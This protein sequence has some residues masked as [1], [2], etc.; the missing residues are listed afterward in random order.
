[1]PHRPPP[2]LLPWRGH[3]GRSEA[4]GENFE[5][6]VLLSPIS[7]LSVAKGCAAEGGSGYWVLRREV[8]GHRLVYGIN[9]CLLYANYTKAKL[10][11]GTSDTSGRD[12]RNEV[13]NYC[14]DRFIRCRAKH[15]L[16]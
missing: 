1:M 10:L 12:V 11:Q 16:E 4:T 3:F 13:S 6:G 15:E 5:A 7:L 14:F 9:F 2:P 8:F